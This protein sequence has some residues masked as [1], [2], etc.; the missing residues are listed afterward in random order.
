MNRR[1]ERLGVL[2][3]FVCVGS[4]AYD[5]KVEHIRRTVNE[6]DISNWLAVEWLV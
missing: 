3:A 4:Y 2:Q 1:V 6:L 5:A